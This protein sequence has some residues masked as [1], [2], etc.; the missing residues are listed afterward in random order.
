MKKLGERNSRL[1]KTDQA[2]NF[3]L[4]AKHKRITGNLT[5]ALIGGIA[6]DTR[7]SEKLFIET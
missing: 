3:F 2:D 6:S 7:L 5:V 1:N 4:H